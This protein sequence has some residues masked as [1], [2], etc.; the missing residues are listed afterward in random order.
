MRGGAELPKGRKKRKDCFQDYIGP[1][2]LLTGHYCEGR[3][4][5]MV[6]GTVPMRYVIA[7]NVVVTMLMSSLM[8]A[9]EPTDATAVTLQAGSMSVD[10]LATLLGTYIWKFDVALPADVKHVEVR[11][12]VTSKGKES[13]Q[14][15]AG[16]SGA[17]VDSSKREILL[18]MM[19]I[20]ESIS[21][22]AKVRLTVLAFGGMAVSTIDNPLKGLG[23]GKPARPEEVADGVFNLIGGYTKGSSIRSPLSV[24]DVVVSLKIETK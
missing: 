4:V 6:A 20:G 10:E 2:E 8:C 16:I 19:P 11:L 9:A 3:I 22:A 1:S 13:V 7:F 14:L 21:E 15:G 12:Q 5:K 23:V 24:A 18:A 17:L